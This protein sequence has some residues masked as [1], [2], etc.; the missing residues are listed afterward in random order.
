LARVS[1]KSPALK[2]KVDAKVHRKFPGISQ[3]KFDKVA[4]DYVK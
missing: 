4:K 3:P 1:N 2:S